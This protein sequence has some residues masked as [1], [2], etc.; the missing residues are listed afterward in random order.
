MDRSARR[1]QH[2]LL[3]RGGGR[4]RGDGLQHSSDFWDDVLMLGS[5]DVTNE[6]RALIEAK[7]YDEA[8]TCLVRAAKSESEY[9]RFLALCR[10]HQHLE[11]LAQRP[12]KT[13]KVAVLGGAEIQLLKDPLRLALA[14][15]CLCCRLHVGSYN[16]FTQ[17]MLNAN[18]DAAS[19]PPDVAVIVN[20]PANIL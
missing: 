15:F 7:C 12:G 5:Q 16:T 14:T 20:T 9:S 11:A 1:G 4:S 6:L 10:R 18:S 3:A 8:W 13:A 19:F 2:R 17:E